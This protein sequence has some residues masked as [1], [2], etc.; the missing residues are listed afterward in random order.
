M[1]LNG[2]GLSISL[3]LRVDDTGPELQTV[4]DFEHSEVAGGALQ[5]RARPDGTGGELCWFCAGFSLT[6]P[7][8]SGR[9]L[10]VHCGYDIHKQGTWLSVDGEPPM[11]GLAPR[12]PFDGTVIHLG[13]GYWLGGRGRELHGEIQN[14]RLVTDAQGAPGSH[15]VPPVTPAV[16]VE[17]LMRGSW[18]AT[19]SLA[20][21]GDEPVVSF[22]PEVGEVQEGVGESL[23]H[24]V[25]FAVREDV[26][27][28][29]HHLNRIHDL[30]YRIRLSLTKRGGLVVAVNDEPSDMAM[31]SNELLAMDMG[32]SGVN[33]WALTAAL[34]SCAQTLCRQ[35]G[36]EASCSFLTAHR[37]RHGQNHI[38][39]DVELG[40]SRYSY[41][42]AEA[43][44]LVR[45]MAI[46]GLDYLEYFKNKHCNRLFN[47]FEIRS[48]GE[49]FNCCPSLLPYSIGNA[50]SIKSIEDVKSS[51]MLK[52]STD[53]VLQHDFR[54][55]RWLHCVLIRDNL[56]EAAGPRSKVKYEPTR[57]RL[58]YDP[59]CNLWCPSCRTE[60]I[61]AKGQQRERFMQLTDEIVLPLLKTANSC[62]MN[63]Y[64]DV[65]ASRACRKILETANT[66]EY[67]NLKFD[68]IT[69][70]VLF[71]AEEWAK[72]PGIHRMVRSIRV[73][74]DAA[75]KETYDQIRLGGD[76]DVLMKNLEFIASLRQ[77]NM[78]QRFMI[79][80]VIQE[81]NFTEM[82]DFARLAKRL[83]CDFAIFEPIM[84]WN[85]FPVEVFER[86]AVHYSTHPRHAEF[87]GEL[88]KIPEV[89]PRVPNIN[90]LDEGWA[91]LHGDSTAAWINF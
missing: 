57:F 85:T 62:M 37:K 79:S 55:C 80:M 90:M 43:G 2:D 31:H 41:E 30:G 44:V 11:T 19:V 56:L 21:Q 60:K 47:D 48:D 68:F 6:T 84:N 23:A 26:I 82:A 59:T 35:G 64:G 70:G 7:V 49:I 5:Y 34:V 14:L 27:G 83:R 72:F 54:Y 73:S 16:L 65:F 76:W 69:N 29:A 71:T 40:Q 39:T 87:Q 12:I 8:Q 3:S 45:N 61:V 38:L 75:R 78:I 89:I 53:S 86:K 25:S 91:E 24:F 36:M 9:W 50:F 18:R 17:T 52:K 67:P 63:G 81:A 20:M 77:Q 28:A 66:E 13:I 22:G 46:G 33:L 51:A 10:E 15:D 58:S 74:I 42:G 32:L 88:A 1:V 4:L